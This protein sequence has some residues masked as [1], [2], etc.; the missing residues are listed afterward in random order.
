MLPNSDL[1]FSDLGAENI[2]D[3]GNCLCERPTL[4]THSLTLI[5]VSSYDQRGCVCPDGGAGVSSGAKIKEQV[6]EVVAKDLT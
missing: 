5:S 6:T 2:R 1:L 3:G 4:A